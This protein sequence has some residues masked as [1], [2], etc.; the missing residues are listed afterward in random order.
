[1][2]DVASDYLTIFG[3]LCNFSNFNIEDKNLIATNIKDIS[4]HLVLTNDHKCYMFNDGEIGELMDENVDKL[5]NNE[6]YKLKN[7]DVKTFN[8]IN[9]GKDI[10]A[11]YNLK[12]MLPDETNSENNIIYLKKD[13]KLMSYKGSHHYKELGLKLKKISSDIV[14]IGGNVKDFYMPVYPMHED[15]VDEDYATSLYLLDNQHNLFRMRIDLITGTKGMDPEIK[16]IDK[17]IQKI[18]DDKHNIDINGNLKKENKIIAEN[19]AKANIFYGE[20]GIL[21]H[22]F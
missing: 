10:V 7:G 3:E 13:G 15:F 11:A 9:L 5:V 16:L 17:N 1:M 20:L 4:R 19:V 21:R 12:F 22:Q 8:Y 18:V 6:F 14:L 2:Y